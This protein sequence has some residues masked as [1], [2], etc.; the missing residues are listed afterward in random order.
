MQNRIEFFV[1]LIGIALFGFFYVSLKEY[2]GGG[3]WF[4][5]VVIKYLLILRAIGFGLK[6]AL[7]RRNLD[8]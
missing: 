2:F 8:A 6:K 3:I 4:A 1:Y 5:V 7:N